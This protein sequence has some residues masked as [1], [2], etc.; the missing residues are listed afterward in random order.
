M[1]K[2]VSAGGLEGRNVRG[3]RK[4]GWE[5]RK[6]VEGRAKKRSGGGGSRLV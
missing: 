5:E 2:R 6:E 4:E 3:G 1:E